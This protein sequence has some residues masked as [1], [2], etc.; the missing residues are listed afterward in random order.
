MC[1][2]R[3][4]DKVNVWVFALAWPTPLNNVTFALSYWVPNLEYYRAVPRSTFFCQFVCQISKLKVIFKFLSTRTN[5]FVH[6]KP[7]QR[8]E[9]V[10]LFRSKSNLRIHTTEDIAVSPPVPERALNPGKNETVCP[11]GAEREDWEYMRIYIT[12]VGVFVFL[13]IVSSATFCVILAKA[14][15]RIHDFMFTRMLKVVTKFFDDHPS[16]IWCSLLE[17]TISQHMSCS[18]QI[19]KCYHIWQRVCSFKELTIFCSYSE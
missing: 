8:T 4:F 9:L 14:S 16:G 5:W 3:V 15:Q 2:R 10:C 1:Y 7:G 6:P 18:Y 13:N 11:L 19:N 17:R 12:L